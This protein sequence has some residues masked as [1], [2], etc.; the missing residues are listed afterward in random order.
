MLFFKSVFTL[1][2]KI[3]LH[4]CRHPKDVLH[5][6]AAY[7]MCIIVFGRQS[8]MCGIRSKWGRYLGVETVCIAKQS[9]HNH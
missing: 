8:L 9:L 5:Y 3:W 2:M 4:L 1:F 6:T 7:C